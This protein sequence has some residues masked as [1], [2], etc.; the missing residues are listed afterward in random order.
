MDIKIVIFSFA[1]GLRKKKMKI[2]LVSKCFP[3]ITDGFDLIVN[4]L[5]ACLEQN[6][7]R[8]KLIKI[9]R[10]KWNEKLTRNQKIN[11]VV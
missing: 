11:K 2:N 6:S 10:T 7:V 8:S 4:S 1:F 9:D 5:G 3:E